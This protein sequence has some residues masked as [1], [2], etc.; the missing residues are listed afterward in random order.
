MTDCAHDPTYRLEN[1]ANGGTGCPF[2]NW[3]ARAR[4]VKDPIID[5]SAPDE[6]RPG[7]IARP[8]VIIDAAR[9]KGDEKAAEY[10]DWRHGERGDGMG[11]NDPERCEAG[12]YG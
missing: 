11:G 7:Y 3:L 5:P 9:A 10:E 6:I 12:G 1:E 8:H 2:C 4:N